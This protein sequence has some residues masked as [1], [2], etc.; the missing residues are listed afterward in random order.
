MKL[1]EPEY[2]ASLLM[3]PVCVPVPDWLKPPLPSGT[4]PQLPLRLVVTWPD[5]HAE[6]S[7][8]ALNAGADIEPGR[9]K[10]TPLAS[11]SM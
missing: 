3:L 5:A 4:S 8:S 10:V 11:V 7:T 1:P 2:E 9:K 6:P